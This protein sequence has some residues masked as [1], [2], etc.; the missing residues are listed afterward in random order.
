MPNDFCMWVVYNN[1]IDL[2]GRYVAR[3]WLNAT[4]TAELIQGVTLEEL[5]G[6]LPGGLFRLDRHDQDDPKIVEVW[7]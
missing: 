5:R 4:P 7:L 3:K 6:R 2:P 1:P